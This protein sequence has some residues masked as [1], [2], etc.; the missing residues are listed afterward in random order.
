MSVLYYLDKK[1]VDVA[2]IA[3]KALNDRK[4][5]SE[6][7]EGILYKKEAVRYNCF[8]VL[9]QLSEQFPDV[10][11]PKWDFFVKLIDEDNAN[12]KYVAIYVIANL[13]KVDS[14]N[15]FETIFDKF[16]GLLNDKSIIPASHL[17]VNSAK[18]IEAKPKLQ[19]SITS[20]LLDI[21]KT[22]HKPERKALIK[23]Y[24]I[25]AFGEYFGKAKNKNQIINFVREQLTSKSPKTRKKATEFLK[26]L[27]GE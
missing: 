5:L 27:G 14:E 16:Y 15:R 11:Y 18:I 12:L 23:S 8:R 6:L 26:K 21:D 9:L 3:E 4:I 7:M 2:S 24:I 10:L 25:E 19:G 22:H 1:D 20:K 13:T 17:A